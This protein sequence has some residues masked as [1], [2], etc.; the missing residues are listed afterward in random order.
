MIIDSDEFIWI[1]AYKPSLYA[2][3]LYFN[4]A[5]S[6]FKRAYALHRMIDFH[7]IVYKLT[8]KKFNNF[9]RA[10]NKNSAQSH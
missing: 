2:A 8:N 3:S 10:L 4:S 1:N 6:L 9:E 7:D 5:L